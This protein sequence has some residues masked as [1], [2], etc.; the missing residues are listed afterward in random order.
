[1]STGEKY[2]AVWLPELVKTEYVETEDSEKR[3]FRKIEDPEN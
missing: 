1:M 3:R 2:F